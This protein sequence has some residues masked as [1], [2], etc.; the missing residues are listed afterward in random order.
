MKW[1]PLRWPSRNS[2]IVVVSDLGIGGNQM[3]D[4]NS[5]HVWM[6]F[7]EEAERRGI[8]MIL[9][10]PYESDRWPAVS[11]AFDTTLTWD[12]E[13]GVQELRHKRRLGKG[14]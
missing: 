8:N 1:Q 13:T 12:T 11:A 9:L 7:L 14:R 4:V 6:T 10:N 5:Q 3:I 2:A